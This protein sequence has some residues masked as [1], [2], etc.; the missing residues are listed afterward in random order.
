MRTRGPRFTS[1]S[2]AGWHSNRRREARLPLLPI[3]PA[4]RLRRVLPFRRWGEGQCE[5]KP[6]EPQPCLAVF[7]TRS[8]PNPDGHGASRSGRI[9]PSGAARFFAW[10]SSFSHSALRSSSRC[11]PLRNGGRG[12]NTAGQPTPTHAPRPH[13]P[14]SN[15]K[16][17]I[18]HRRV[19]EQKPHRPM[20]AASSRC[21]SC[22]VGLRPGWPTC[23][24]LRFTAPSRCHRRRPTRRSRL[25]DGYARS[26]GRRRDG[27]SGPRVYSRL[28]PYWKSFVPQ[29]SVERC[30]PR[31]S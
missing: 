14:I 24:K 16:H 17:E 18:S 12:A 5:D 8:P 31:W 13:L 11:P 3:P 2:S 23:S 15:G 27:G 1:T 25:F 22:R 30:G 19:P 21:E 10:P 26:C 9:L 28:R 29:V 20:S 6:A 7:G 4:D